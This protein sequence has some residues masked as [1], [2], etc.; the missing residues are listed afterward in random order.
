MA[1]TRQ[2]IKAFQTVKGFH[3][4]NA[5]AGAAQRELPAGFLQFF[6]LLHGKFAA[7][8]RALVQ[9]RRAALEQSLH[10]N[11]PAY[12]PPSAATREDWRIEVP[13]WGADQRNQM[14]GPPAHAALVAQF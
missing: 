14:T 11:K 5:P 2:S 10:G 13:A 9:A 6:A 4:N 1:G 3:T 12:P 8:H 7:R